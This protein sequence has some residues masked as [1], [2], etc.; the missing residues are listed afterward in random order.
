VTHNGIT[1]EE[2]TPKL[3]DSAGFLGA[4]CALRLPHE[5]KHRHATYR[6][7]TC[8]RHV[9]VEAAY[10]WQVSPRGASRP[11]EHSR[12]LRAVVY[13]A[14]MPT[15]PF[16]DPSRTSAAIADEF[17]HVAA[18]YDLL[19]RLNP[20]YSKHLAW[21]ARRLRAG[22]RARI[23][24]LCCGTGLS[25]EAIVATYPDASVTG[26]DVSAGMLEVARRKPALRHVRFVQGDAMDLA[27]SGA[28]GPYDA[29][30]MAY[31]I[32]NVPDPDTCLLRLREHIVPGGRIAFHEYLVSGSLWHRAVWNAVAGSIII[33][34]GTLATGRGELFRYLRKSVNEFDGRRAF[35]AR[36]RTAGFHDVHTEPMSGWQRGIEHTV[37]ATR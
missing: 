33:P 2:W 26:L 11:L 36:V 35:E 4:R 18:R 10:R 6:F 27:A 13:H 19:Q 28:A 12:T 29:V 14:R 24:D 9:R 15:V 16:V 25:T 30:L 31:G 1:A 22:A 5:Y 20:G 23:L 8:E 21:S 37:I 32:R 3:P 7:D 17:D 34:L